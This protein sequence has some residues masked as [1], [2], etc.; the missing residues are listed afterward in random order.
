MA[1][2]Q[3]GLSKKSIKG[4]SFKNSK[5][6]KLFASERLYMRVAWCSFSKGKRA[7]AKIR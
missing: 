1:K 4:F 5:G 2:K 7:V 3:P 6:C